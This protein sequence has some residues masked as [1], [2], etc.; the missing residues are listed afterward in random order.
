M[1]AAARIAM[2]I[3]ATCVPGHIKRPS[4]VTGARANSSRYSSLFGP[5]KC[6][7][8]CIGRKLGGGAGRRY[9]RVA[10]NRASSRGIARPSSSSLRSFVTRSTMPGA[11]RGLLN[12]QA[13]SSRSPPCA[14][15]AATSSMILSR[16]STLTWSRAVLARRKLTNTAPTNV[17]VMAIMNETKIFQKRPTVATP[18][19]GPRRSR[20]RGCYG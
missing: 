20:C 19:E 1:I 2:L 3:T 15:A 13:L 8:S 7:V 17:T 16:P 18:A 4:T 14:S 11:G 9:G 5:I 10:S 6:G 12:N